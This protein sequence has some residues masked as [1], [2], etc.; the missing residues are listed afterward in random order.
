MSCSL[1]WSLKGKA[2]ITCDP[3]DGMV[4]LG[5]EWT[6]TLYTHEVL[7]WAL[8]EEMGVKGTSRSKDLPLQVP[9]SP[10]TVTQVCKQ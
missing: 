3:A 5:L 9:T 6:P 7:G 8:G 10:M 1:S 4:R 2:E